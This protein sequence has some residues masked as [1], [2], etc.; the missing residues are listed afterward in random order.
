MKKL[1]QAA[2]SVLNLKMDFFLKKD[3]FYR[4]SCM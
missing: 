3:E 4:E 2:V 1:I